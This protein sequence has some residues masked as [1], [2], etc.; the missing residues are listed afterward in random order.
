M[1]KDENQ[2]HQLLRQQ[3]LLTSQLDASGRE[4]FSLYERYREGDLTRD[5]YLEEKENLTRR[6]VQMQEQLH[7]C[8]EALGERQHAF[9]KVSDKQKSLGGMEELTEEQLRL[10]LYDAVE[11]VV[12]WDENSIEIVWKF[13]QP[14]RTA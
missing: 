12:I 7:K 13:D 10:H 5:A 8:Q 3:S 14:L 1:R 9:E 4:K 6:Q 2:L 11:R